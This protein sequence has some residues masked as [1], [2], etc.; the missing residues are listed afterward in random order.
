ML[1][2]AVARCLASPCSGRVL[3]APWPV[4]SGMF[5]SAWW[6]EVD[7]VRWKWVGMEG[8]ASAPP[9]VD[10]LAQLRWVLGSMILV[11]RNPCF[12]EAGDS[13]ARGHRS[14]S[15]G[16]VLA[17][18]WLPFSGLRET[19]GPSTGDG[20]IASFFFEGVVLLFEES[21]WWASRMFSLE[22]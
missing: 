14:F 5:Q 2:L 7:V 13:D 18:I 8:R 19:F 4:S 12:E 15:G 22:K 10:P 16:V 9:V 17:L 3:V 11:R 6:L 21:R 20:V 1:P